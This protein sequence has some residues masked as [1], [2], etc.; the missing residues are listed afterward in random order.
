MVGNFFMPYK[1]IVFVKLEKRLLN[2]SRWFGMS[3]AAQLIYVK[4][5]LI[6]AETYNRIPAKIGVLTSLLRTNSR[7]STILNAIKEIELNFPKFKKVDDFYIFED[8]E[9]KTNYV[10]DIQRNAL[11]TPKEAVYKDKDKEEDKEENKFPALPAE[12]SEKDVIKE[13]TSRGFLESDG[14]SFYSYYKAQDWKTKGGIS[15]KKNWQ[16]KI[17]GWMNNQKQYNYENKNK[18]SQPVVDER[19]EKSITRLN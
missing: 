8:F 5:I 2:D 18:T 10:R 15:I 4:L 3:E 16:H 12:P 14:Q 9:S 13:F 17:M 6:A 1:N 19:Y 11:G 7:R